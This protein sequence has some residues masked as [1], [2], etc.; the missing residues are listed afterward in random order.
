[1]DIARRA[2][3]GHV[4]ADRLREPR[5]A[6]VEIIH[7]D[8]RAELHLR[9]APGGGDRVIAGRACAIVR[10][11]VAG[12]IVHYESGYSSLFNCESVKSTRTIFS[13]SNKSV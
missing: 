4:L 11:D 12:R 10:G 5:F 9:D 13:S 2:G 1:M 6:V 3:V 7:P 8:L